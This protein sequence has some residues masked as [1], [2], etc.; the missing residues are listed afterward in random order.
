MKKVYLLPLLLLPIFTISAQCLIQEVVL[1]ERIHTSEYIVEG[2]VIAQKSFWD[3]LYHNIYTANTIELYKVFKG[4]INEHKTIEL[5]TRGGVV[6]EDM[7]I[8]YPSLRLKVGDVGLFLL[9]S[10][11]VKNKNIAKNNALYCTSEHI[12]QGYLQYDLA[13][14]KA[15]DAFHIY[16]DVPNQLY[17]QIE[18]AINQRHQKISSFNFDKAVVA[19]Q[20]SLAKNITSFSPTTTNAG[21]QSV[22]TINGSGFGLTEGTVEFSNADNGGFTINIPALSSEIVSWSDNKIEVEVPTDAGTGGFE[23][24]TSSGTIFPSGTNLTILYNQLNAIFL[25]NANPTQFVNENGE[26]GFSFQFFTD[27]ANDIDLTGASDAFR[28]AMNTWCQSTGINW[29]IGENSNIDAASN[30]GENVV[31][32]DNGNELP[33]STLGRASTR[34]AGCG[35]NNWYVTG[36]DI[37]FNDNFS[38]NTALDATSGGLFDLESVALHE[39]GHAHQLGHTINGSPF[40]GDV[41]YFQTA[42]NTDKR[43]PTLNDESGADEV[44]NRSTGNSVCF[45]PIMEVSDCGSLPVELIS[46]D[47]N[48]VNEQVLLSWKT[49]SEIDNAGFEIQHSQD[50]RSWETLGFVKG[51]GTTLEEQNYKYYDQFP[52][53]GIN[54]YRLKQMDTDETYEYSELVSINQKGEKEERLTVYPNPASTSVHISI[55][56][57]D[58]IPYNFQL[59][60]PLGRIIK[61]WASE[62]KHRYTLPIEDLANGSYMIIAKNNR[63]ALT[64]RFVKQ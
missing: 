32:F 59:V 20:P 36:I 37:V 11:N 26:G 29:T 34:W 13:K 40:S 47:G 3:Y 49:A 62:N 46:F 38:W 5:I 2:K 61:T 8:D 30:D 43:T 54:Y 14:G 51:F 58:Q 7:Q 31:R 6:G 35:Q 60:D 42:A 24:I 4:S 18:Q 64:Y 56:T 27:F 23:V 63:N 57:K 21:T 19:Q 33:S 48:L 53:L 15:S 9:T 52:E 41:M 10:N 1:E 44:S 12:S 28:R 55:E 22:L 17:T 16:E 50:A 45:Q 39:L 25:G